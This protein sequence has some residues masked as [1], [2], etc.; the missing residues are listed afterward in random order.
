MLRG[1]TRPMLAPV[2]GSRR[3][4]LGLAA[5]L[6]LFAGVLVLAALNQEPTSSGTAAPASGSS[7]AVLSVV[8][9][10]QTIPA[11][12][13]I[14]AEMLELREMPLVAVLSG[15]IESPELVVGS[16]ARIPIYSG[17]QL[18]AAKMATRGEGAAGLSY[19]VPSG[20]RAVAVR[21]DKVV[22][23]GG[24]IRPGDRVDVLGL[25][26]PL[27]DKGRAILGEKIAVTLAQNVQVLAV[28]Q[29]L[30]NRPVASSLAGDAALADGT[31]LEQ[32]EAQPGGTVATLAVTPL[33]AEQIFGAEE[34]G[35][36]RLSVRAP[37]DTAVVI[38]Q[39]SVPQPVAQALSAVVPFGMRAMA[40]G[41]DKVVG[42]GGLL[43]PGDRVDVVA[44]LD[45]QQMD[46]V[47]SPL[48]RAARAVTIAQ[49][50]EVLSVEQV[51]DKDAAALASSVGAD[52]ALAQPTATVA[53]LAVT[54]QQVQEILLTE[55][56]GVIRLAVRAPGDEAELELDDST[57]F[58]VTDPSF[59]A[60][61]EEAF[62][63]LGQE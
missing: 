23:A 10:S 16:F 40:V 3:A 9:A 13:E 14:Q 11:G 18:V 20:L 42:G 33:Q 17:E 21:V 8:V 22:G 48:F 53:T 15:A 43:L 24:L 2:L 51:I 38:T 39:P 35:A 58:S 7:A 37:G 60:L 63:A 26:N 41:I 61:I 6:A 30:V 50:I 52:G 4:R 46:F 27:D 28:E 32:P 55:T 57:F 62:R 19:I 31:L 29:D 45:V 25:I 44:V 1:L 36:V 12:T 59:Q 34:T 54:P 5:M 47:G 49:N 56:Q